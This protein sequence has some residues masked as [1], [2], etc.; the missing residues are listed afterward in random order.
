MPSPIGGGSL[1]TS[2]P[3]GGIEVGKRIM[4]PDLG[5][6][7]HS[8]PEEALKANQRL[9]VERSRGASGG[10]NQDPDRISISNKGG[11]K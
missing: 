7:L 3:L 6:D 2:V 9:E 4:Y 10:C 11:K 5:G 8:T 1:G